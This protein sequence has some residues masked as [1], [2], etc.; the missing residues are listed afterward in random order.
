MATAVRTLA[1][2]F[3]RFAGEPRRLWGGASGN[4][5]R[6]RELE[7][8]RMRARHFA[9]AE[10][11]PRALQ[12]DRRAGADPRYFDWDVVRAGAAQGMLSLLIPTAAGG[13]GGLATQGAVVLEELC[14]ACPGIVNI[15]GAHALGIAPLLL[16]GPRFWDGVLAELVRAEGSGEPLLMACAITEPEAGTDVEDPELLRTARLGSHARRVPGGFRLS[17][18]KRFI[19]N[20]SVARY[21]TV[22]MP[23]DPRRVVETWTCFLVDSRSDGFA[24]SRVEHKMG[25][26]ACPA[27]ELTFDEVFVP[28]ELVVGREGDGSPATMI[29]LACSR[30]PVGAIATGIAR[31]AYERL[32][33]WLREDPAARGLLERQHVQLALAEMEEEIHLAR[34]VYMD[35]A[36]ELDTAALGATLGHPLVRALELVPPGVRG[37]TVVR[38]RLTSERGRDMTIA[39]LHRTTSD[40]AL[41]RSV[42]LSS[43]AK[44]RGADVAMRVTSAAL[45]LVGLRAGPVRAELEKLMRDA[46]LTQIYE[47]TNQLN[48]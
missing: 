19:S 17:G 15:F 46:K 39:L 32:L 18:T 25:Q 38:E 28:D 11:R 2:D 22:M 8:L 48:R 45:D 7:S 33:G 29:V 44:A 6:G 31:G 16:A 27:A 13:T 23:V 1:E 12:I 9:D 4:G 43:M 14:A 35:A 21:I 20:G 42:G 34:Q 40:R 5:G 10:I 3:P 41:S 47:G 26:R 36:T 30:P 24:V 37:R